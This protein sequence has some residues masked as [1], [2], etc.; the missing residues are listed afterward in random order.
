MR[1]R[2][3]IVAVCLLGFA[4]FCLAY[5]FLTHETLIDIAWDA[6][7][8]PVLLS[9][10]P[11]A[12]PEELREARA[13]AYGGSTIQDAGYYPFGHE[14]FSDLAHYVRTGD[15]ITNLIRESHNINELAFSLGALSH[16]VG[17]SVG[18]RYAVNISVPQEF[19]GLRDKY[20]SVVTY[21]EDPHAHVRTEFAFDIDQ[22][23]HARFAPSGYLRHVGFRV[24]LQLLNRAFYDTY[25]ITLHSVIGD[26]FPAF[27]TYAWSVRTLLPRVGYAEVLLHRRSFPADADDAAFHEYADRLQA[28][29]AANHWDAYRKRKPSM[30]TRVFAVLIFITPKV[31]ALSDLA[32]RGPKSDTE[33]D[34]VSSVNRATAEYAELLK[35]LQNIGKNTFEVP[36]LDL[37]T[38]FV[39]RPGTYRLTD[40]TYA[41]LLGRV[42]ATSAKPPLGLRQNILAFYA[43]PNAPIVTKRH[44]KQWRKVQAELAEL[45]SMPAT[46]IPNAK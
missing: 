24:P 33:Q 37:D 1:W 9:R 31:S 39:T 29:D 16:Y 46:R 13:Y 7:I 12:T 41:K 23:G 18:H 6:S 11:N 22:L 28:T 2:P 20:G 40:A 14:F 21:E 45:R 42:T 26:E 32:I 38:G 35:K 3:V 4:P 19:A 30:L 15:F 17:D 5:S 44:P 8:K 36:D 25:G 27:R 10:Y 34:Y 43:D